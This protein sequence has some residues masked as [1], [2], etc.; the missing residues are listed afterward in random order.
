MNQLI[1]IASVTDE[2]SAEI[3]VFH[4]NAKAVL[5]VW[6]KSDSGFELK[7]NPNSPVLNY[8]EE[9]QEW[10]REENDNLCDTAITI[11]VVEL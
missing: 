1:I 8:L 3:E 2:L 11:K 9:Y 6:E 10:C 7:P 5:H 4:S